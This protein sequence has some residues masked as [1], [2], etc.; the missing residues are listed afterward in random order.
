[1]KVYLLQHSRD[2]ENEED[3]KMIGVYSSFEKAQ[4]GQDRAAKLEGFRDFQDG[5]SID[6]YSV[7]EDCWTDGFVTES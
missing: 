4:E 1:M 6:E 5:F 2:I 3:V 7:D